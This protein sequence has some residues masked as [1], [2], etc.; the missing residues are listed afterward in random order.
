ML[1]YYKNGFIWF[2]IKII[3]FFLCNVEVIWYVIYKGDVV[4]SG[5]VF[6][7][8]YVLVLIFVMFGCVYFSGVDV[9]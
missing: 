4:F 1:W 2:Y 6:C 8:F 5:F 7:G 3:Y 9:W